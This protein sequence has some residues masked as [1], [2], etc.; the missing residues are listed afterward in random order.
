MMISRQTQ[1]LDTGEYF[2]IFVCGKC[3]WLASWAMRTA[4]ST[5]TDDE[6]RV[7]IT[8]VFEFTSSSTLILWLDYNSFAL[9]TSSLTGAWSNI[10]HLRFVCSR[11]R[12]S[13]YSSLLTDC[14]CLMVIHSPFLLPPSIRRSS[15]A[16][17]KEWSMCRHS[18]SCATSARNGHER[19]M[20][21]EKQ[22]SSMCKQT[23]AKMQVRRRL[24]IEQKQSIRLLFVL[25]AIE[26]GKKADPFPSSISLTDWLERK[27]RPIQYH[28][29][30]WEWSI[31]RTDG[32]FIP[33]RFSSA[34]KGIIIIQQ[35]VEDRVWWRRNG[36]HLTDEES[37]GHAECQ[38]LD[39]SSLAVR[40]PSSRS[41]SNEKRVT[42]M[43]STTDLSRLSTLE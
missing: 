24:S 30:S 9:T 16:W 42:V 35:T 31:E 12:W 20:R 28:T 32:H 43:V 11:R 2:L 14:G 23:V 27:A 33:E 3:Q 13:S 21:R 40:L 15:I 19:Q 37:D 8:F 26:T 18:L 25:F 22:W 39:G 5:V 38:W 17:R 4:A 29:S 10:V 41:S 36:Q 6:R 1:C 7:G 34:E